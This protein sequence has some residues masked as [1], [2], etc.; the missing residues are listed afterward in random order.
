MAFRAGSRSSGRNSGM[1]I[2]TALTTTGT[3][4]H[5]C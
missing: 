5:R 2:D 1:L 3:I 4:L